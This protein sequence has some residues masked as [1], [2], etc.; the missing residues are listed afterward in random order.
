MRVSEYYSFNRTQPT[1]DFVDVD[2]EG[3]ASVFI[4]PRAL[5][6]LPSEW[7]NECVSLIQNF[8]REVLKAIQAGDQER[9]RSL[10]LALREPNET[11]LGLS[12]G[13]ARGRAIGLYSAGAVWDALSQSEAARSGLLE[14]LEDTI[15]MIEGISSDIIS[16]IATNIIREPLIRYTQEVA[17]Y[18]GIP[19]VPDVNS[20]PMWDPENVRW[21]SAFTSLPVTE[22]GKL[23][24][25]PKV[26]VRRRMDY[27]VGEY[28]RH[29]LLEHLREAELSANT[30]LVHLL[31]DGSPKVNKKDVEAKYGSGKAMIVRETRNHPEILDEYR[32]DKRN[33]YQP[34]LDHLDISLAEG[35]PQPEWDILLQTLIEIP[36]GQDY[37]SQYENSVEALL[38]ALFYPSLTNPVKQLQ[39]HEGRKRI[40][41][42]YTNVASHGFFHWLSMHHSASHIFIECKNYG[43]ELGNPELDQMGGRFSPSR[44]QF[45]IITCRSFENKDLFIKRCRDTANDQRGFIVPLDDEDL[46]VLVDEVKE[47]VH[48]A[49]FEFLYSCFAKLVM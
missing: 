11:H 36:T 16:D 12:R 8:F 13:R 30:E 47:Q 5:R 10:L 4:D 22:E 33:R 42:T 23:L 32:K 37:F 24:L 29:Y 27:D 41:L 40:D 49:R 6:L 25:V 21:Y 9:G 18:Y 2:I 15:L 31:R 48:E 26:I 38:S 7:G 46:K 3:D 43:R 28:F 34:P 14:E 19:L 17:E 45:G 44:G 35:T 20:G 39:I 1:L